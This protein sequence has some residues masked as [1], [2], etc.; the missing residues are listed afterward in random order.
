MSQKKNDF[1]S[2]LIKDGIK[3]GSD[4]GFPS[5]KFKCNPSLKLFSK[6]SFALHED[7]FF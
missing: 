6:A 5:V 4:I 3:C 1:V 2:G 7:S